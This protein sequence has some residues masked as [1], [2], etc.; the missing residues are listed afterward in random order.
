M[1]EAFLTRK[2]NLTISSSYRPALKYIV[3]RFLGSGQGNVHRL[4]Y[5]VSVLAFTDREAK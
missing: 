3:K 2:Y 1:E 5:P 4:I